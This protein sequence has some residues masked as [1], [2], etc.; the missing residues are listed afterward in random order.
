MIESKDFANTGNQTAT[1]ANVAEQ[2][3][4]NYAQQKPVAAN[5]HD[6]KLK[7]WTFQDRSPFGSAPIARGVGSEYIVKLAGILGEK[8]KAAPATFKYNLIS[9][10]RLIDSQIWFSA[11]VFCMADAKNDKA[12][13][14][15]TL[16]LEATNI[17]IAPLT[18]PSG[19]PNENIPVEVFRPSSDA[20]DAE[21]MK[22]V[23]ARVRDQFPGAKQLSTLAT[24]VPRD[25]N[26]VDQ[27]LIHQL[28]VQI[29]L[30]N[31]T[32]LSIN[33]PDFTDI[34]LSNMVNDSRL[35]VTP[36]YTKGVTIDA[37]DHPIRSD[38]TINFSAKK[39]GTGNG[40]NETSVNVGDNVAQIS[41]LTGFIDFMYSPVLPPDVT[42][43]GAY[44]HQLKPGVIPTQTYAARLVITNLENYFATT[45][46]GNLL[47]LTTAL[48]ASEN[49]NWM[50]T[51]LPSNRLVG[52]KP[53]MMH[54]VGG[55][56]I[57]TIGNG[58]RI[59]TDGDAFRPEDMGKLIGMT[60]REG[61]TLS[62]DVPDCAPNT[63][64]LK[65]FSAAASAREGEFTPAMAAICN[66][67]NYLT[68][69]AFDRNFN[70]NSPMFVDKG[71]RVHLG[72]YT[73]KEGE[74]RDIRDYDYL[75]VANITGEA[76]PRD[77][78][79][80]SDTFAQVNLPLVPR[81]AARKRIISNLQPNA[82]FTGYG[83]RV[84]FSSQ[85]MT[86]L[87]ISCREAGFAPVLSTQYGTAGMNNQRGVNS[88]V[89]DAAMGSN[90]GVFQSASNGW[91]GSNT[92]GYGGRW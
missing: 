25:F 78:R 10:D 81:L 20:F 70:K 46:P 52:G 54:D 60:V 82:V 91:N 28:A 44:Q 23:S 89:G 40:N 84:T 56:G 11:L 17:A 57:E 61:L 49:G 19:M 59:N 67:A 26:M 33:A 45:L 53:F 6:G 64:G 51:F 29:S 83:H 16:I 1:Q 21:L 36:T 77:I 22:L 92:F 85:F 42:N 5:P 63:W 37:V 24:V 65:V 90:N 76:D 18:K 39:N 41:Q 43:F 50:Q 31:T 69:G 32:E 62:L 87:A 75:S 15:H 58:K 74:K 30:A 88:F 13:A 55:L 47:S 86:A 79:Q 68:N 4:V 34:N 48:A 71:N 80:W 38:I 73:T 14:F 9:I 27:N 2:Q 7:P 8:F 12:V 3:P 35:T 72:Y 66:A